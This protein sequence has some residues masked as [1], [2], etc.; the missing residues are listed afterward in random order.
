[1]DISGLDKAQVLASLY[2][3]AKPIGLGALHFEGQ[4]MTL[5]EAQELLKGG[6]TYIDYLKGRVMKIDLSG[7]HIDTFLYNRDNGLGSAERVLQELSK[8]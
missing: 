3:N 5:E 7:D 4:G 6:V 8:K 1:M 2:N